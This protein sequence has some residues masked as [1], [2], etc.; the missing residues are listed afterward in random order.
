M[1][2]VSYVVVGEESIFSVVIV[3]SGN[4]F[5]VTTVAVTFC[6]GGGKL[7]VV[8]E[9]CTQDSVDEVTGD[10]A[11]DGGALIVVTKGGGLVLS[12]GMTGI[13]S[14]VVHVTKEGAVE[15]P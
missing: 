12:G 7:R 15:V 6:C 8:R 10:A 2:L 14:T 3:L 1:L 9:I 5:V 11:V 4:G 13:S